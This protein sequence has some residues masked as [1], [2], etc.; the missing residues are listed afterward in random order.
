MGVMPTIHSSRHRF[1]ARLNSTVRCHSM[2][3][4][5]LLSILVGLWLPHLSL[6]CRLHSFLRRARFGTSQIIGRVAQCSARERLNRRVDSHSGS[7]ERLPQLRA[8]CAADLASDR[9]D[10]RQWLHHGTDV[11]HVLEARGRVPVALVD[12]ALGAVRVQEQVVLQGSG[13]LGAHD[14]H[15]LRGE[16]LEL[17]EPAFADDDPRRAVDLV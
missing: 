8:G 17:L 13:V 5:R 3:L 11:G 2:R 1:A 10:L 12:E 14:L 4:P 15:A 9:A 7:L 16:A 6:P